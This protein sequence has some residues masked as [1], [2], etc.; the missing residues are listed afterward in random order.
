M[1]FRAIEPFSAYRAQSVAGEPRLEGLIT[2]WRAD[3]DLGV[4]DVLTDSSISLEAHRW[5]W[6]PD[7]MVATANKKGNHDSSSDASEPQDYWGFQDC[8]ILTFGGD[9]C[10]RGTVERA[11]RADIVV[12]RIRL[13]QRSCGGRDGAEKSQEPARWEAPDYGMNKDLTYSTAV[14][15]ILRHT[16][17]RHRFFGIV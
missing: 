6:E 10:R 4:Q 11:L 1:T 7:H 5:S 15:I 2:A 12:H 8:P 9:S 13:G 3:R 17:L 14:R 16:R